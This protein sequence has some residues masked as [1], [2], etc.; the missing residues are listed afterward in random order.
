ML[1]A[2]ADKNLQVAVALPSTDKPVTGTVSVDLLDA[3][4]KTLATKESKLSKFDS[5]AEI[6]FTFADVKK[7]DDLKLRVKFD[8]KQAEM[9]LCQGAARQRA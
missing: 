5:S 2:F 9:P 4:G 3:A 1:A 8:N 7:A 6:S